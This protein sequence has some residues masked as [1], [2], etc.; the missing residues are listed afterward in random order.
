[1]NRKKG[2]EMAAAGDQAK[3]GARSYKTPS[4]PRKRVD[5]KKLDKQSGKKV[6]KKVLVVGDWVVD[7]NWMVTTENSTT[8]SHVGMQQYRSV[9]ERTEAQILSLCAAGS[10]ALMLHGAS[11]KNETSDKNKAPVSERGCFGVRSCVKTLSRVTRH[12]VRNVKACERLKMGDNPL[13]IIHGAPED[14]GFYEALVVD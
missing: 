14:N 1:M 2:Q 5:K 10:I 4:S 6:L 11:D 7:E 9:I 12:A 3:K 8:S 13:L